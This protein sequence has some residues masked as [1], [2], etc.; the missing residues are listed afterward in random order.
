M[1]TK[2]Q[3]AKKKTLNERMDESKKTKM[4]KH[5][6]NERERVSEKERMKINEPLSYNLYV[7]SDLRNALTA[8]EIRFLPRKVSSIDY[9]SSLKRAMILFV[10]EEKLL[11]IVS[12]KSSFRNSTFCS[13]R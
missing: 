7:C 8:P 9:W 11:E 6:G 1:K 5:K 3:K 2:A 13:V 12:F 10:S 4:N